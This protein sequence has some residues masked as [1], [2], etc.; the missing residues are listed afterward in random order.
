MQ[1]KTKKSTPKGAFLSTP[2]GVTISPSA[3]KIFFEVKRSATIFCE[4]CN[5]VFL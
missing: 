4:S 2:P 3:A 1:E 5:D